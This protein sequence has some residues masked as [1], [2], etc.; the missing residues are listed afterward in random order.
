MEITS[1]KAS[2]CLSLRFTHHTHNLLLGLF[3]LKGYEGMTGKFKMYVKMGGPRK[4]NVCK[5][6]VSYAIFVLVY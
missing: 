2:H 5:E 4:K 3:H 6:G 1:G